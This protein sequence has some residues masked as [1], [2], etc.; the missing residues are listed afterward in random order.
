MRL[1]LFTLALRLCAAAI[2]KLIMLTGLAVSAAI[3]CLNLKCL[4][5]NKAWSMMRPLLASLIHR[6]QELCSAVIC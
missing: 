5:L 3:Y 4:I 1:A 2:A 6:S